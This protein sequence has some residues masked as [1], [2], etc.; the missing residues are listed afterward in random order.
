MQRTIS[1]GQTFFVKFIFPAFWITVF[2]A[3]TLGLFLASFRDNTDAALESMKWLFL[4]M[5][6]LGSAFL[7]WSCAR[8]K[9]VRMDGESLYISNYREEIRVAL[10]DVSAVSENR[11]LSIHPVTVEFCGDSA[12]GNRIVFIPKVRW[13]GAWRSHSIVSELRDAARQVGAS[14]FTTA[15]DVND[16][17]S[18]TS[19]SKNVWTRRIKIGLAIAVSVAA[20]VVFLL[21]FIER[22]IKSSEV[23]QLSLAKAQTANAVSEYIGYPLREGWLVSGSLTES[24]GGMG[25][26]VLSIPITGPKGS[27]RLHVEA[28]RRAGEWTFRTFQLEV[29]G[30][31]SDIDLLSQ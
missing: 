5:W 15:V 2:G 12:F 8:L 1:S 16:A 14:G 17:S 25:D 10:H 13:W 4:A 27:G 23:Y 18:E 20:F 11:W 28:Q 9:R 6:L 22:I 24:V 21:L 29:V 3:G 26:A 31:Q 7:Y 19:G 30:Q